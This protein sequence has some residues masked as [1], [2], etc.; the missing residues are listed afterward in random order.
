MATL[1]GDCGNAK[2][3][4]HT[5]M[6]RY[7][8]GMTRKKARRGCR[9]V[10]SLI[11]MS[12][13]SNEDN[14]AEMITRA[15]AGDSEA[16]AELLES[17]RAYLGILAKVQIDARLRG[18]VSE[19]DVVQDTMLRASQAFPNF[20]GR[21]ENELIGWL[22]RIL[23]SRLTDIVRHYHADMRDVKLEQRVQVDVDK[24]SALMSRVIVTPGPSPSGEA[25][26]REHAVI[27]ANALK[28]IRPDYR[29]VIVLRHFESLSF[30]EIGKRMGRSTDS[31][32]NMWVRAI[33]KLR[34]IMGA[35]RD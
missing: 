28:Q 32:K 29:E 20:R 26:K 22:R 5:H 6:L 2:T 16:L 25:Q 31:V 3:A 9:Q 21:S 27:L 34:G 7:D 33:A 23:A 13:L 24:S 14:T 17:Y 4:Q 35:S 30:P 15:T 10:T 1:T 19:S 12:T 11:W 18:K 8:I